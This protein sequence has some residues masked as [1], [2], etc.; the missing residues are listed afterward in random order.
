MEVRP[1]DKILK[2]IFK[3]MIVAGHKLRVGEVNAVAGNIA[4]VS[5]IRMGLNWMVGEGYVV[6]TRMVMP[7]GEGRYKYYQLT[8]AGIEYAATAIDW[9]EPTKTL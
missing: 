9:N 2:A 7:G 8:A 6:R 1:E 3:A 5:Q 4:P